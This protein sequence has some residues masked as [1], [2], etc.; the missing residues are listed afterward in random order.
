MANP[1]EN[2]L[3]YHLEFF[4][5]VL[6]F[7][8]V[9]PLVDA[10]LINLIPDPCTFDFHLRQQMMQ[11]AKERSEQMDLD[12]QS[13]PRLKEL[14]DL[15]LKRDLLLWPRDAQRRRLRKLYSEMDEVDLDSSMEALR[16]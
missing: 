15:D 9:A 5:T 13:D 14:M 12:I 1:T 16:G 6:F 3:S 8:T 11:M 2:P 7:L 4:G 10:G